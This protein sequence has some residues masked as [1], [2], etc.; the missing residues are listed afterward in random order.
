LATRPIANINVRTEPMDR[1]PQTV[2]LDFPIDSAKAEPETFRKRW[3]IDATKSPIPAAEA[4][5]PFVASNV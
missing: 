2:P 1:Y 4:I 3:E 5:R